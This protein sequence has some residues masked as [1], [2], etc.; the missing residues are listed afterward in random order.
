MH[1]WYYEIQIIVP[2]FLPSGADESNFLE[3][4]PSVTNEIIWMIYQISHLGY[5][6][7]IGEVYSIFIQTKKQL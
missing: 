7:M 1:N 3:S 5:S 6:I 4:I 2:I